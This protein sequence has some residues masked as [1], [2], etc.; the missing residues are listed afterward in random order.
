MIWPGGIWERGMVVLTAKGE[1]GTIL[2]AREVLIVI[3]GHSK[4]RALAQ[5]VEHGV[6]HMW[7]VSALQLHPKGIIVCDEAACDEL[8]VG[9]ARYFKDTERSHVDP[10]TVFAGI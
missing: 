4:A 1:R 2:D 7:T 3:S 6:N 10:R 9:T 5:V 8:R